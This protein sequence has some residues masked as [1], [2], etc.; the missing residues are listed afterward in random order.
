M[1]SYAHIL[2]GELNSGTRI[3]R[4]ELVG[5]SFILSMLT[6]FFLE[7]P[8][9]FGMRARGGVIYVLAAGITIIGVFGLMVYLMEGLPGRGNMREL[10]DALKQFDSFSVW[11]EDAKRNQER[12]QAYIG[13][14]YSYI[15]RPAFTDVGSDETVAVIGDS[16]AE[17]AYWGIAELGRE[18][19]YNTLCLLRLTPAGER[20]NW[21]KANV[22]VD[23]SHIQGIP[24][25]VNILKEKRDIKKVFICTRGNIYMNIINDQIGNKKD[26]FG[27]M[28]FKESLQS[29]VDVLRRY[30]KEVFII[31]EHPELPVSPR[32]YIGRPFS[33]HIKQGAFPEV[34]KA[35]IRKEQ[36]KYLQLLKEIRNAT[37]IDVID[38]F[39]GGGETVSVFTEDGIPLYSDSHHLTSAG[40]EFQAEHILRP[41][42]E[43]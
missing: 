9:R 43:R 7:K 14:E 38:Q 27:Y 4:L 3:L 37:I 30:G 25:I 36:A 24:V 22:G 17:A 12:T 21:A 33:Q 23:E 20:I 34:R 8:I 40:S 1:I 32:A 16:H 5:V 2:Y 29:Y 42:L 6:Y 39:C 31:A 10:T 19:H 15:E 11:M 35:D 28:L 18:L 26:D 41:Y 13:A